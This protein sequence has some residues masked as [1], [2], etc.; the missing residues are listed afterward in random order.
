MILVAEMVGDPAAVVD[1]ADEDV[2]SARAG[3]LSPETFAELA[4][5]AYH[6]GDPDH[7]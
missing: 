5:I 7:A 6:R 2:L 4:G 3:D 1:A